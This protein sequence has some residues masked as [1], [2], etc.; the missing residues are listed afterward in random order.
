MDESTKVAE[1]A[2][3]LEEI[4]RLVPP[5]PITSSLASTWQVT[6]GRKLDLRKLY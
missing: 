5:L 3:V 1:Q 2:R 6:E 4:L